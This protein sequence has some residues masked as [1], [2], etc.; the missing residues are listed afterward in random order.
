MPSIGKGV[1]ELKTDDEAKWYRLMYLARIGDVIHV[2]DCFEKDTRKTET[3]DLD[4]SLSRLKRVQQ[5]L[6]EK[7]KNAKHSQQAK[8][9]NQR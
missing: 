8:P 5:R 7:R 4:R 9:R 2:L 1:Y 3:K 6:L